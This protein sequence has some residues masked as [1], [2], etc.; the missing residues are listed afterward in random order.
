MSGKW[1]L[2]GG[3]ALFGVS[4]AVQPLFGNQVAKP[5]AKPECLVIIGNMNGNL[6]PCGCTSPMTGGLKRLGTLV[7]QQRSLYPRTYLLIN[8]GTVKSA[9]TQ[10]EVGFQQSVLKAKLIAETAQEL[11][12]SVVNMDSTFAGY[13][14]SLIAE[15]QI[16]A[17][18]CLLQGATVEP[19]PSAPSSL[20]LSNYHHFGSFLI[21]VADKNP[22]VIANALG[23]AQEPTNQN[24]AQLVYQAQMKGLTPVLLLHGNLNLATSIAQNFP[25]LGLIAYASKG[26]APQSETK[27]GQVW[28]VS[29]GDDGKTAAI[30]TFASHKFITY[31]AQHLT[32]NFQD[33]KRIAHLFHQY[34]HEVDA[35]NLLAQLPRFKTGQYVGSKACLSCHADS[36]H[37]WIHSAHAHAYHDLIVR[38]HQKDPDCV[39]CHVTGLD[40]IYGFRSLQSTPKFANVTCES[41]HGPGKLHC[42]FP[43][44][45][46]V[47]NGQ[48]SCIS[49][50]TPQN[51]PNF[52]FD[53]YWQRIIHK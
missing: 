38:G 51:S 19:S 21:G 17:P 27:V 34:L 3:F 9:G 8:G 33:S 47:L 45:H 30:V 12:P 11:A 37:I 32:P 4:L 16:L 10:S 26:S 48:Q 43:K 29:N 14:Q 6:T 44:T 2:I 13:G 7:K 15:M 18:Q 40:S 22:S 24:V 1:N 36:Y 31:R 41:C 46:P 28:L 52:D 20:S 53:K 42:E 35:A 39:K 49:C 50:H 25:Q 23:K 5:Q